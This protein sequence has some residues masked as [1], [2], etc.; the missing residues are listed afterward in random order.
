MELLKRSSDKNILVL[1]TPTAARLLSLTCP[2]LPFW[3]LRLSPLFSVLPAAC[4]R[5][6]PP[7]AASPRPGSRETRTEFPLD[8]AP[9]RCLWHK[10][11]KNVSATKQEQCAVDLH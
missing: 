11:Y 1:Y 6:L 2:P 5:R 7:V 4:A 3:L 9:R 8:S 10:G